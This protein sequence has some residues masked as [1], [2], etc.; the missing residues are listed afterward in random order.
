[1][2]QFVWTALVTLM[3]LIVYAAMGIRVARA[4][5]KFQIAAPAMTGDPV[6]ERYVRVQLNTLEWLAIFLPSLWLSAAYWGDAVAAIAGGV[7]IVGR[8]LYMTSYVADPK[9][10]GAGFAIQGVAAL[11][12]LVAALAGVVQNLIGAYAG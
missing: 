5:S 4:R 1:M 7:W 6:F 11:G 2:E 8:I 10:R 3:A 12:L 9:S